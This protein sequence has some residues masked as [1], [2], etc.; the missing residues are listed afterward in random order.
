[1]MLTVPS[2]LSRVEKDWEWH[3]NGL[4]EPRREMSISGLDENDR[5][6]MLRSMVP[7]RLD[8]EDILTRIERKVSALAAFKAEEPR[9][10][11]ASGR[12]VWGCGEKA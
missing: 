1:M 8:G 5:W 12:C 7:R 11:R 3:G 9:V 2:I 4:S 6:R 10:A